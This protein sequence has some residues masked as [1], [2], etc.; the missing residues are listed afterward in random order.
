MG[1]RVVALTDGKL[2]RYGTWTHA[3]LSKTAIFGSSDHPII[4]LTFTKL[5]LNV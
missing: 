4:I 1:Q 5:L 2:L 3:F